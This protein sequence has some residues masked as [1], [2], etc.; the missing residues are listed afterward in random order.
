MPAS[1]PF[2]A[3]LALFAAG[4]ASGQPLE[5]PGAQFNL[6]PLS[7]PELPA[8]QAPDA[9]T[10]PTAPAGPQPIDPAAPSPPAGATAPAPQ[11]DVTQLTLRR[12]AREGELRLSRADGGLAATLTLEGRGVTDAQEICRVTI[13]D[14]AAGGVRLEPVPS[15]GRYARYR[16]AA[17]ACPVVLTLFSD[18]ALVAHEGFCTFE[19][20]DCRVDPNGMWGPEPEAL[21][22]DPERIARDRAEADEDVR[23]A[24]RMMT[25][26]SDGDALRAVLAEQ[27][28]FSAERVTAC[29]RFAGEEAHGLCAARFTQARA[30][31]LQQRLG[32]LPPPAAAGAETDAAPGA[33]PLSILPQ[34]N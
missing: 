27:A 20:A 16:L 15:L 13:A 11:A 33:A 14:E 28:G 3:L 34:D 12:D 24:Y 19:A 1:A 23:A 17:P 7:V 21:P 9:P 26:R 31:L 10:A 4:S 18:A 30:A 29:A 32:F 5:L 8:P 22:T 25:E 2:V 6:P